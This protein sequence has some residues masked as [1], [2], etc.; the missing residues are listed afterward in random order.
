MRADEIAAAT[1][2]SEPAQAQ[3]SRILIGG[4]NDPR[5]TELNIFND[6]INTLRRAVIKKKY[7][8]IIAQLKEYNRSGDDEAYKQMIRKSLE[9]KYQM[10][11]L[12][13]S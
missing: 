5:D 11:K 9:L 13:G 6:S 3:L 7:D 2:L 8:V 4:T 10:D 1:E 12:K